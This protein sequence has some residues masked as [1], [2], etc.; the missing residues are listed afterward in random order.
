MTRHNLLYYRGWLNTGDLELSQPNQHPILEF[1]ESEGRLQ[2][3]A[4]RYGDVAKF[5]GIEISVARGALKFDDVIANRQHDRRL[6]I[7]RGDNLKMS[8]KPEGLYL[9]LEWAADSISQDTRIM[10]ADKRLR[11]LSLE[12]N[13][14]REEYNSKAK[15][16]K[17]LEAQVNGVAIVD[18]PAFPKATINAMLAD[19][20]IW[21]PPKT[22]RA[23]TRR[24]LSMGL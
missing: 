17:I 7:A 10:V 1:E 15:S 14:I 3:W 20:K 16:T 5:W 2:G 24:R 12:L 22:A 13:V 9:E 11:G 19:G 18:R 4:I 8:D 6:P 23:L 21:T